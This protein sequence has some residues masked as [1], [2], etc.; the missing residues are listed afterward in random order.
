M[1]GSHHPTESAPGV[2]THAHRWIRFVG[3]AGVAAIVAAQAYG[4]TMSPPDRDMGNLQKI[5]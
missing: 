3:V 1:T 5:M 2:G 4:F